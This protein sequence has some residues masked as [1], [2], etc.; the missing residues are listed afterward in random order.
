VGQGAGCAQPVL[1]GEGSR[2]RQRSPGRS[3][4]PRTFVDAADPRLE[5]RIRAVQGEV[6][7]EDQVKHVGVGLVA[8]EAVLEERKRGAVGCRELAE[9]VVAPGEEA[10]EELE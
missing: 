4:G 10:F 6:L 9:E 2:E 7:L 5:P 8:D 1:G 3:L